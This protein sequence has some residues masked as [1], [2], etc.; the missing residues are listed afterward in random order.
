MQ[1]MVDS[2]RQEGAVI[3]SGVLLSINICLTIDG[4]DIDQTLGL[5]VLVN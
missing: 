2:K 4:G 3:M 1:L 5:S